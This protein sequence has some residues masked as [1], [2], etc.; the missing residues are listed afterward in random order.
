[1]VL[2][3]GGKITRRI[4]LGAAAAAFTY[5]FF[6]EYL[7]PFS[8]L[9]I[10]FDLH[11]YHYSLL[12]Y[13][14]QSLKLG[15]FP[16]W[17]PTEYS[18]MSLA[19]NIQA[20]LFY[21]PAWLLFA[22]NAGREF[23]SYATLEI[24]LIAHVWLAFVLC[25]VWLRRRSLQPLACSFGAGVFAFSGYV[26]TQ[27]QHLGL[28]AGYAWFPLGF[29]GI[30]DAARRQSWTPLWK[31]AVASALCLVA[32]Y[33]PTWFAFA[34][35][36][37]AYALLTSRPVKAVTGVA[38]A[39]GFSLLLAA[40][41]ALPA[42]ESTVL[43]SPDAHYGD[44]IKN[45]AY[46]LSM[47][48]PNYYQFSIQLPVLTNLG[49]D[50]LYLGAPAF[51]GLIWIFRRRKP[52]E[53][54][55]ILA[56]LIA[57]AIF[58]TNPFGIVWAVIQ[59]SRLIAAICR[60][61]YF[62]APVWFALAA[63]AAY[64]IDEF[65][66][67]PARPLPPRISIVIS[68]VLILLVARGVGWELRKYTVDH[69]PEGIR[70]LY[71]A[72]IAFV[73]FG[74]ILFALRPQKGLWRI[75]LAA[76]LLL[77]TGVDYKVFGTTKRFNGALGSGEPDFTLSTFPEL[78]PAAF[79]EIKSHAE[80]RVLLADGP[81]PMA[82]RQTGLL[83]AQGFD[84][85]VPD[86]YRQLLAGKAVFSNDR[87]FEIDPERKDVLRLLGIRYVITNDS[88][89]SYARMAA[90]P[91]FR[92]LGKTK[93]YWAFE[94][95]NAV[96][97]FGWESATG[98]IDL[99]SWRPARRVLHASSSQGGRFVLREN[100][101]PGWEASIDGKPSHIE[102]W[103]GIF[104]SVEVPPGEHSIEFRYHSPA[105]RRGAYISGAAFLLLIAFIFASR[106]RRNN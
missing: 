31:T 36:L 32:G 40:I 7:P 88:H 99:V 23:M 76:A 59:H 48:A 63:L 74:A 54:L 103:S 87:T 78:E 97:P 4:A 90:D 12:N 1:M 21:P 95:I 82:I 92:S 18:G 80:Y 20:E 9:N 71:I 15:T 37:I 6:F 28:I 50:Y 42:A 69:L 30:D 105:L 62:L 3:F 34:V 39:L 65:L 11:G 104:Q 89:P 5:A 98:Q 45:P 102:P 24:F 73:L 64:G 57:T 77:M 67:R 72:L 93:Y 41:Q 47:L 13:A 106:K 14:F 26:C 46:Y 33:P 8:T 2:R 49:K 79:A 83:M 22:A 43:M 75:A 61:W 55:P 101:F 29:M 53:I 38:A 35:S 56:A 51:F 68:V 96:P 84:P 100:I 85:F 60:D 44:G 10:P 52:R 70:S 17:D 91:E 94:Y 25:Y 66:S 86:Q 19:G 58:L 16:Q 27:L 81:P